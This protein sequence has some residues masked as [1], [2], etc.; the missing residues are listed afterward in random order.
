VQC[1]NLT[2]VTAVRYVQYTGYTRAVTG[3]EL[4]HGGEEAGELVHPEVPEPSLTVDKE[5]VRLK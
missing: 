4:L 2:A 1:E 5:A 3:P